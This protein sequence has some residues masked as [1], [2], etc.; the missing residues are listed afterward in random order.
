MPYH[1]QLY[2]IFTT[3]EPLTERQQANLLAAIR[4]L[5]MGFGGD[6][7]GLERLEELE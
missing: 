7:S 4:N 2:H 1:Y 5:V 6:D 3:L